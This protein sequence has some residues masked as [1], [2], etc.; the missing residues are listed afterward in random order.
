M[1]L[2]ILWRNLR[3]IFSLRLASE[4]KSAANSMDKYGTMPWQNYRTS[5]L[6]QTFAESLLLSLIN[7]LSV[8]APV[9]AGFLVF[10]FSCMSCVSTNLYLASLAVGRSIDCCG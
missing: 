8:Y 4:I 10:Y 9:Y 1:A 7:L 2:V 5:I 6:H 3:E